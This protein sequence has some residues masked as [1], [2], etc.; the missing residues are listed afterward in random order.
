MYWKTK[1][2]SENQTPG[3]HILILFQ[4]L[5]NLILI[6]KQKYNIF[7][8]PPVFNIFLHSDLVSFILEAIVYNFRS[9]NKWI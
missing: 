1:T 5:T 7:V 8:T 9:R 4:N 6:E 2:L 3:V